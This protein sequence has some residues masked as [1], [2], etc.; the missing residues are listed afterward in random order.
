MLSSKRTTWAMPAKCP[1][2]FSLWYH[3]NAQA[4]QSSN[5][6]CWPQFTTLFADV[7]PINLKAEVTLVTVPFETQASWADLWLKLLTTMNKFNFFPILIQNQKQL[8]LLSIFIHSVPKSLIRFWLRVPCSAPGWKHL[9]SLCFSFI[10]VFPSLSDSGKYD[11][12]LRMA[13]CVF[14]VCLWCLL[15]VCFFMEFWELY[16]RKASSTFADRRASLRWCNIHKSG[17]ECVKGSAATNKNEDDRGAQRVIL[18]IRDGPVF[19]A[20]YVFVSVSVTS[21]QHTEPIVSHSPRSPS[22]QNVM[23]QSEVGDS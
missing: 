4:S 6:R 19:C 1:S 15:F 8:G 17:T 13:T 7:F 9:H 3:T 20:G 21:C 5:M 10:Q 18:T 16:E 12:G 14:C 22:L 2:V 23:T 11:L